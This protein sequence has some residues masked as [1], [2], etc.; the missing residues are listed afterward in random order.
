MGAFVTKIIQKQYGVLF[1]TSPMFEIVSSPKQQTIYN[2]QSLMIN[3]YNQPY[4]HPAN[5]TKRDHYPICASSNSSKSQI[6]KRRRKMQETQSS[7]PVRWLGQG[8]S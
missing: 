1:I 6:K 8:L 2:L 7:S 5:T 3:L 4:N